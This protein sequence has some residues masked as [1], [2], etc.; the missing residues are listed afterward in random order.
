MLLHVNKHEE[1]MKENHQKLVLQQKNKNA[2]QQI[3]KYLKRNL[4]TCIFCY[5]HQEH[6]YDS[7]TT[8]TCELYIDDI[9]LSNKMRV[10]AQKL[11]AITL[12]NKETEKPTILCSQC[13]LPYFLCHNIRVN[14]FHNYKKC[15][16]QD[17]MFGIYYM[18]YYKKKSYISFQ[19]YQTEYVE[20]EV[21]NY[22]NF[23]SNQH[24]L[25]SYESSEAFYLYVKL[26]KEVYKVSLLKD[27]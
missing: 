10:K 1:I 17:E 9:K 5:I 22:E 14:V 7:H 11:Y 15:H 20:H 18:I 23:L 12:K 13:F 21:N 16:V 6:D 26:L 4:N 2:M 19:F 3:F 27:D 8:S 24:D 25:F